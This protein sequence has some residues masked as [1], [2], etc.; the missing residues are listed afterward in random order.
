MHDRSTTTAARDA[1]SLTLVSFCKLPC[2]CYVR[3]HL[4]SVR[5]WLDGAPLPLTRFPQ[6]GLLLLWLFRVES[7]EQPNGCLGETAVLRK[8]HLS[9]PLLQLA[10]YSCM[11]VCI[12][13]ILQA[14]M[15]WR[16]HGNNRI[17]ADLSG[18]GRSTAEFFS[19]QSQHKI[20]QAKIEDSEKRQSK[21]IVKCTLF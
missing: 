14:G 11:F 13:S 12:V 17:P 1:V 5:T 18:K 16:Y 3:L 2:G 15:L 9:Y 8:A 10:T 21:V 20:S 6:Y 7:H 19:R 4:R